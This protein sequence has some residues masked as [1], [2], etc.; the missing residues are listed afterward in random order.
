MRLSV[1]TMTASDIDNALSVIITSST[2]ISATPRSL[3]GQVQVHIS[4]RHIQRD[5][6]VGHCATSSS[7]Q[8]TMREE[9]TGRT[10]Q[11]RHRCLHAQGETH[12]PNAQQIGIEAI[13]R[14]HI[15]TPRTVGQ[16]RG[17]NFDDRP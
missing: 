2:R 5:L 13:A 8:A 3:M 4:R 10:A 7:G 15:R 1:E 9:Q 17:R 11:R 12:S 16:K 6:D 14:E